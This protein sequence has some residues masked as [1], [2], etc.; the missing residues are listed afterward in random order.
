MATVDT[1]G[2]RDRGDDPQKRFKDIQQEHYKK[3]RDHI[4]QLHLDAGS[5]CP[6][7]IL[8]PV[9]MHMRNLLPSA[10]FLEYK[11][12]QDISWHEISLEKWTGLTPDEQ[13][14]LKKDVWHYSRTSLD[15]Q[16]RQ[17]VAEY[18]R[19]VK[20]DQEVWHK[21]HVVTFAF[22]C[23]EERATYL[24]EVAE[25]SL[26]AYVSAHRREFTREMEEKNAE[27]VRNMGSITMRQRQAR[28]AN[29]VEN[30]IV[31][32]LCTAGAAHLLQFVVV[33]AGR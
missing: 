32:S 11:K 12:I 23:S 8:W 30:L 15:H 19:V 13:G 14:N 17:A 27:F 31:R 9:D 33:C 7:Y 16:Q 24:T 20:E 3:S 21:K 22:P 18:V 6:P 5:A 25:N 10:N 2:A 29:H 28:D 26:L 4:R 1:E